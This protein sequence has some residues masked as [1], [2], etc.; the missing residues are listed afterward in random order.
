MEGAGISVPTATGH[1]KADSHLG[2]IW[3]GPESQTPHR[4]APIEEHREHIWPLVLLTA[5]QVGGHMLQ[6][7]DLLD[8]LSAG[9]MDHKHPVTGG[10]V[11]QSVRK[12]QQSWA[13][14]GLPQATLCF[15]SIPT[16]GAF[17]QPV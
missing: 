13:R 3:A 16:P 1:C 10:Q 9:E 4:G 6:D 8:S 5:P 15:H 11:L 12:E 17:R 7:L 2:L 14:V